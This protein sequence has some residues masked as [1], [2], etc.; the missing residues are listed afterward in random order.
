M[1]RS[2]NRVQLIGN[3]TRD[4]EL[5]YTPSGTAVCTF[6]LATNRSWTTES[7]EKKEDA[8][9]HRIVAW[10][11]LAELCSQFLTK[12]RKV[13]VEGRLSTRNWTGQDGSQ[14]TTTE[15]VISDMILLD[16]K[17]T[18]KEEVIEDVQEETKE[19]EKKGKSKSSSKT[20]KEEE[21]SED[22]EVSPE[23]IPF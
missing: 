18:R 2:L 9:F 21:I 5:R 1:A 4:P 12:G 13:F 8:E 14:R 23:D 6:G 3:L 19:E 10:N 22:E 15:I 7:G 17:G 11:K 16:N 20:E